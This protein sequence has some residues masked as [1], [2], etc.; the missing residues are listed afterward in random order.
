MRIMKMRLWLAVAI[1]TVGGFAEAQITRGGI[2]G[3]VRDSSAGLVPGAT[4]TTTDTATNATRTAQTDSQGFFSIEALEPGTY[5][6]AVELAG[7]SRVNNQGVA[8][9]T[10]SDTSVDVVLQPG[11]VA[12]E[13]TVTAERTTLP[14]NRVSPTIATTIGSRAVVELPLTDGR[15]INTLVLTVPN[16]V[17]TTGQGT[18]AINGQRPRN[19]NYM[20]DGSDNNDVAATIATSQIVP[21]AVAEFQVQTNS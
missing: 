1:L 13:V 19:N 14:L 21:E 15:N 2:V 17:S 9:R 10:A 8:V 20:V 11:G 12:A 18:Y 3:T 7:F 4:V 16:A 6:V 5:D